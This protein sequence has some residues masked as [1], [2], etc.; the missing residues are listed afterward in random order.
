[1]TFECKVTGEFLEK[2][3]RTAFKENDFLPLSSESLN[4]FLI[5]AFRKLEEEIFLLNPEVLE[6]FTLVE[7]TKMGSLRL[8]GMM[9]KL[10]AIENGVLSIQ[11]LK[12]Q[13]IKGIIAKSNLT[14][15]LNDEEIVFACNAGEVKHILKPNLHNIQVLEFITLRQEFFRRLR[16]FNLTEEIFVKKVLKLVEPQISLKSFF[17]LFENNE[18]NLNLILFYLVLFYIIEGMGRVKKK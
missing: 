12:D 14:P 17:K 16:G 11:E 1:M 4:G 18:G 13:I 8:S 3:L 6:N 5:K 7:E 10:Q 15:A 2:A 9:E